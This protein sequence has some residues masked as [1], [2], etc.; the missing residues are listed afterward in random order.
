MLRAYDQKTGQQVGDYIA[1]SLPSA[2]QSRD[3]RGGSSQ[4]GP[5][6]FTPGVIRVIGLS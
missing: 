4:D 6:Q 2:N 5:P 3:R 1:N